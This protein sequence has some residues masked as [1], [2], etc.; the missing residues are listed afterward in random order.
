M[1]IML[2]G[3]KGGCDMLSEK[4][5]QIRKEKGI[6]QED[7]AEKLNVVRQTVSKWEKGFSVPDTEMLI[8]IAEALDTPVNELLS[9]I[10]EAADS[11]NP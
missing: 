5:K 10:I 9:E 8:R 7:L 2:V 6:S 1:R 4:L 3:S 11:G